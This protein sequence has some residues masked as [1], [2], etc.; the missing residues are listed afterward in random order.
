MDFRFG[1]NMVGVCSDTHIKLFPCIMI[2][3]AKSLLYSCVV[4]F[5]SV[6]IL[7]VPNKPNEKLIHLH[8]MISNLAILF[9]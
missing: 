6:Y 9:G 3:M 1:T 5:S 8:F 7:Q 4:V 2:A